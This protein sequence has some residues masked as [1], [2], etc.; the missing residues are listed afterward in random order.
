MAAKIEEAMQLARELIAELREVRVAL[1]QL[2][3]ERRAGVR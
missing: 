2:L 3:A 1:A